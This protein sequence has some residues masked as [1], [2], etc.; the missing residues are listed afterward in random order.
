VKNIKVLTKRKEIIK[1][2]RKISKVLAK[3]KRKNQN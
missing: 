3:K 2:E 1:I